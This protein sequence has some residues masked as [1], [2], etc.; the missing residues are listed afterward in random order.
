MLGRSARSRSSAAPLRAGP[1]SPATP[2][3]AHAPVTSQRCAIRTDLADAG[4]WVR[5]YAVRMPETSGRTRADGCCPRRRA[6]HP[7]PSVPASANSSPPCSRSASSP[8]VVV[9]SLLIDLAPSWAK[10]AAIALFG[11]A[12]QGRAARGHRA[13]AARG[14]RRSRRARGAAPAVGPRRLSGSSASSARSPRRRGRTPRCS[15]SRRRRIA[16]IAGVIALQFLV[17]RLPVTDAARAGDGC[18]G[19]GGSRRR[20]LRRTPPAC[21]PRARRRRPA[22]VPR[23]GGRRGGDRRARR[24]R[25]LRAAGGHPRGHRDPRHDHAAAGHGDARPCHPVPSSASTGLTPVITPN[26]QFYRIDT[27]L[28]V[29]AVDPSTWSLRIHGMVEREVTITW[30]ELLALPLEESI[31]T[32]ACVSNEV[33]GGLIGNA[34]WLG[35]PIRELLARAAPTADADMVLSRSVDGFTASTPLEV[36]EDDRNA[37]LAVGMNGDP[38]PAE[39]GF[40]VRMVVPGLYGYVSATKWVV[41]LEVTR[42]DAASAYWTDRGWSERGPDQAAVAHRRAARRTVAHGRADHRRGRRVAPA[43][44]HRGRRRAGRRRPVAAGDARDGD[45][46]RHLGAVAVRVGCD[47]RLAHRCA[48]GRPAPTARCRPRSGR[49]SC[50]TARPGCTSAPSTSAERS[51]NPVARRRTSAVS[52]STCTPRS[53]NPGDPAIL[54]ARARGRAQCCSCEHRHRYFGTSVL[55]YRICREIGPSSRS[56]PSRMFLL[57]QAISRAAKG[58]RNDE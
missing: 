4:R 43:R 36:L 41:D 53:R 38:L 42:F 50:P 20:R 11:T 55:R 34:V 24:H 40:P 17:R 13:R 23:L 47:G 12:R 32:L 48:C 49:A 51:C 28:A 1:A 3:S 9:G 18:R 29:P 14:R 30:D 15:R 46:G 37:I 21:T 39:H 57:Q 52:S 5:A 22:T 16:A 6:W 58:E 56:R 26:A 8:F 35:Y 7:S 54:A 33:G 25:G 2:D 19:A 27:A 31:T 44:R 45:L 10:D